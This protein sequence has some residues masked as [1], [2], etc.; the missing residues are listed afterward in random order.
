MIQGFAVHAAG[1][2]LHTFKYDP[3]A[4][5]PSDV[6][7]TIS[8]CGVCHSD[9]SLI[10]NE[11]GFSKYPFIPGHEV[12]G[13]VAAVG[14]NVKHLKA[15]DQVG[16]GWQ[17][18]SCGY[19]EWCRRGEENLCAQATP[20][21]VGRHG[22]FAERIRVDARFAILIPEGMDAAATAPLLCGGITVYSPMRLHNVNASSRVGIIGIGGLGHMALQFARACGADVTAFSS[23]ADKEKE[24]LDLGAHHFVN[25]RET[26]SLKALG[27]KFDFILSTINVDQDWSAYVTAL[28]PHGSLVFVGIP[29]KPATFP[30]F[31]LISGVKSISGCNIGSPMQIAEMLD[32][33]SR[34]NIRA[35][36]ENFAMRD[37]N[38]AV[39]RARKSA[40]RYRAVLAN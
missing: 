1:A 39:E 10:D 12:V 40:V 30:V 36:V 17:A 9:V 20:T 6:E 5:R 27:S 32:V 29:P 13:T 35:V 3:G 25:T 14:E 11:W 19:C 15:G 23:S 18:D 24:A 28:R 2:E 7:I 31:P 21:C 26:K 4:L 33:A 37:A 22:G 8:H 34:H 38:A 16:V